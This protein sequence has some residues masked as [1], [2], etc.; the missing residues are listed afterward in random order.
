LDDNEKCE[1]EDLRKKL[2]VSRTLSRRLVPGSH[3]TKTAQEIGR[4]IKSFTTR[5]KASREAG[6]AQAAK[7]G[8][9]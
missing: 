2:R 1:V 5:E 3:E 8:D 4:Q 9:N 6:G 7:S